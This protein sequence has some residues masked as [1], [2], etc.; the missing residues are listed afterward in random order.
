MARL[1][2]CFLL[3]CI[4]APGAAAQPAGQR[5]VVISFHDVAD[6]AEDL[7]FDAVSTGRLAQF[8]DW[9][10]G[11]GWAA[12]TLDDLTAAHRGARPLPDK[13]IV[14]TFDDGYRSLYTHVYPLL[15]VYHFP[16]VSAL[17]GSWMEGPQDGTVLYGDYR[18]PR[19]NFITWAEAREMQA[20][21]LVEFA[22]HSY[23]LHRV[24]QANPQG[25]TSPAA[26]TWRYDPK[27]NRYENDAQYASRIR[28]D[29]VRARNLLQ[30]NLGR[31]PRAIVWPFGRYTGP[32]LDVAKQL[33]FSLSFTLE[34]EPAYTSDLFAIHRYFPTR[35][36]PI[37]E[38]AANLR[39][40]P[41]RP[42]T[43]RIACLRLDEMAAAGSAAA[44]DEMLGRIIEGLR[45]LGANTVMIHAYA[46]LPSEDAPLGDVYFPTSLRPMRADLLSRVAW[47]LHKR[48]DTEVY[49]HLP[50]DPAAAA[51]R[52]DQIP[53]LFRD[54][55]KYTVSDGLAFNTRTLPDLPDKVP[56]QAGLIRAQRAA[57]NASQYTG[58]KR[59][60]VEA[61]RATEMV[62]PRQRLMA[63]MHEQE[64]PPAW[65]D[66]GVMPPTRDAS[67][68]AKLAA[69][70]RNEGWLR[71]ELAGRVAFSLPSRVDKQVEALRAAQQLGAAT[72]ALCPEAPALPPAPALATAF[73]SATYSRKP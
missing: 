16:I 24:V 31:A 10:K 64:G 68:T 6:R 63:V 33:G 22:S 58:R 56:D 61:Y 41:H 18:V 15:K 21:G 4:G 8:F 47:Q 73:S 71:P 1:L 53:Q 59:L 54:M 57:I 39:F 36:P 49:L 67:D 3:L 32:G 7:D 19:S 38:I 35:N 28:A 34:A 13:S 9:L 11:T 30:A 20:S 12:V 69:R 5:F 45:T 62:D 40:E 52:S 44:Q 2:L 14:I 55:A 66:I 37:G 23:D 43:R 50:L 48:A 51:L 29:L 25:T 42:E 46:A 60:A 65:A 72:F 70:L 27:T 17:V 26:V